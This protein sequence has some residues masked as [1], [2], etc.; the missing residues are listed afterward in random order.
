MKLQC[1]NERKVQLGTQNQASCFLLPCMRENEVT[2]LFFERQNGKSKRAKCVCA[3][4]NRLISPRQVR[5]EPGDR[6]CTPGV[7]A[8][9]AGSSEQAEAQ[10]FQPNEL[11][12]S[13][14]AAVLTRHFWPGSN[15]TALR[16][17]DPEGDAA[18]RG[19]HQ[20]YNWQ[21]VIAACEAFMEALSAA[22]GTA[23]LVWP[24]EPGKGK[25]VLYDQ[26]VFEEAFP[27]TWTEMDA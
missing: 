5:R 18:R 25:P 11:P 1:K 8:A 15:Q 7:Q 13:I 23:T 16:A 2:E 21:R 24:E 22:A 19:R 6:F 12:G 9:S 27:L 10:G 3:V 14:Q 20:G 4:V 17:P 26:A